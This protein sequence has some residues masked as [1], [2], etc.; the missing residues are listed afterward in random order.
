MSWHE[1][2]KLDPSHYIYYSTDPGLGRYVEDDAGEFRA[3]DRPDM[4]LFFE[5]G[6]RGDVSTITN[7]YSRA[8]NKYMKTFQP[9]EISKYI[10]YLD[11]NNLYGRAISKPLPVGGFK[12][13]SDGELENMMQDHLKISSCTLEVDLEYPDG[14]H[15]LHGD[16]PLAPENITMNGTPKLI[17]NLRNK[18]HYMLHNQNLRLYI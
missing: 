17:P 10:Q 8:N 4:Y 14:L 6:I 7:R 9:E 3:I 18:S 15:D 13:L 16:Y 12:W 5:S 11:A 2:Y 1:K